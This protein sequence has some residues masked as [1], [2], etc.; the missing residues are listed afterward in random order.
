MK[1]RDLAADL[2]MCEAVMSGPWEVIPVSAEFSDEGKVIASFEITLPV[3]SVSFPEAEAIAQFI[4]AAREGWPEAIRHAID[5]ETELAWARAQNLELAAQNTIMRKALE[6]YA[7]TNPIRD[8]VY[9]HGR[10]AKE[11]LSISADQA[12]NDRL[13]TLEK[14]AELA[15]KV[16]ECMFTIGL[17]QMA[18]MPEQVVKDGYRTLVQAIQE[19]GETVKKLKDIQGT[20]R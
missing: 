17:Q 11:A 15:E 18:E 3:E 7:T 13:K 16:D 2:T 4:A 20:G 6:F 9:E 1:E 5:A 10:L 12:Y 14:I 19:M 8:G